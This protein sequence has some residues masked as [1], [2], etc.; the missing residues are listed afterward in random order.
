MCWCGD[1]GLS[2]VTL[3]MD[4]QAMQEC[5]WIWWLLIQM[6]W[7]LSTA[8]NTHV[9]Y[10]RRGSVYFIS[11]FRLTLAHDDYNHDHDPVAASSSSSS[12][13]SFTL[14]SGWH[15][16]D[17][18]VQDP[19]SLLPNDDVFLNESTFYSELYVDSVSHLS[20]GRDLRNSFGHHLEPPPP[21]LSSHPFPTAIII[22]SLDPL[23]SIHSIV[24]GSAPG[25]LVSASFLISFSRCTLL[26]PG[27]TLLSCFFHLLPLILLLCSFIIVPFHVLSN[28]RNK[29]RR[30]RR[31]ITMRRMMI[32]IFGSRYLWQIFSRRMSSSWIDLSLT[33][34]GSFSSSSW[35]SAAASSWFRW[36]TT[37]FIILLLPLLLSLSFHLALACLL[38]L[39]HSNYCKEEEEG[40]SFRHVVLFY[41]S[42]PPPLSCS[43]TSHS[44]SFSPLNWFI[45]THPVWNPSCIC[46][47][48][49]YIT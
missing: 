27:R 31:K 42:F 18:Y 6:V 45:P 35:L 9:I 28:A 2:W 25:F 21:A 7:S 40:V 16:G 30:R 48:P 1:D 41:P 12:S 4:N 11:F 20:V 22:R 47:Y 24:K 33:P 19:L 29:R 23:S 13:S 43:I 26:L 49:K 44:I 8:H 17:M 5:L 32:R 37:S 10:S 15:E 3:A 46:C 34:S 14:T 38:L 39:T 36:W